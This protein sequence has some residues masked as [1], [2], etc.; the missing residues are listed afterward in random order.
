MRTVQE[1]ADFISDEFGLLL[2]ADDIRRNLDDL[3]GWNSVNMLRLIVVLERA[4]GR[5]FSLPAFLEADSLERIYTMAI[6]EQT[7]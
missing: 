5:S 4:T 1:F 2:T 7:G 6:G 3:P